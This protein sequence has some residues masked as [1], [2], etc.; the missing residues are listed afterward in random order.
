MEATTQHNEQVEPTGTQGKDFSK[1]ITYNKMLG[2]LFSKHEHNHYA[3]VIAFTSPDQ[4]LY[5]YLKPMN[6]FKKV[7]LIKSKIETGGMGYFFE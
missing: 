6:D 2:T 7:H 3:L 1:T 4:N 5:V